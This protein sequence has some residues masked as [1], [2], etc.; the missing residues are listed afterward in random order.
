[1]AGKV[2][3]SCGQRDRE[4]SIARKIAN[5][6]REEFQLQPYLAFK[7]QSLQ[8]I[9]TI[10]E[11]LESSD[12][13]LFV[14][15]LRKGDGNEGLPCSL[16]THQEL[17]LARHLGFRDM[18]ALQEEGAPLEGFLRYVLSNPE[19]FDTEADLLN[20][21]RALVRNRGWRHDYSRNL[22]FAELQSDGPLV[23]QDHTGSHTMKVWNA[24]IVNHRPDVAAVRTVCILT[25]IESGG[26]RFPSTDRAY[27]KWCGQ[28][29]YENTILPEDFGVV[30]LCSTHQDQ[31]G[32]FLVSARDVIPRS[33][34]VEQNGE[35]LL[36][37]KVFSEGFPLL[38]FSVKFHLQWEKPTLSV[39]D[40]SSACIAN[41]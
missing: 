28:A 10:T 18:V 37:F 26:G 12:Y 2:F 33:P 39:W 25:D 20:K 24:K 11:E 5:L 9:M 23:Y 16:F 30:T 22:V 19:H 36:H 31:Q 13:Y 35:Y 1:V 17:A 27:L 15:F 21:I 29:T 8:D 4:R 41:V 38:R 34:I 3:I 40:S 32:L 6:L 7:T 14:D